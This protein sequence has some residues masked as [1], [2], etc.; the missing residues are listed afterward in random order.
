MRLTSA[1]RSAVVASLLLATPV[2]AAESTPAQ[3]ST[4]GMEQGHH[5]EHRGHKHKWRFARLEERLNRAVAEGRLSQTQA[6]QF[7]NEGQQLRDEMKAQREAAGGKLTDEQRTQMR[8]KMRAFKEKVKS[9]V[10]PKDGQSSSTQK[11]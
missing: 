2:L 3:P 6:D 5:G 4:L 9:A 7:K 10:K 1:L 11:L 8:E